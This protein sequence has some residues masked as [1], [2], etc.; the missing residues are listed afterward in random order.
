MRPRPLHLTAL[1]A[2]ALAA[3]TVANAQPAPVEADTAQARAHFDRGVL[4]FDRGDTEGALVEFQRAWELS[5]RPG[6]LFN[7]A[8]A[9]QAL[10]RYGEAAAALR[11]FLAEAPGD[12]PQ[13]PAA[14]RALRELE[15]LVAHV[16]VTVDPTDAVVTLDGRRQVDASDLV[17]GPGTHRIGAAREGFGAADEELTVASGE[18]RVVRLSLRPLAPVAP[19]LVVSPVAPA[20][21]PSDGGAAGGAMRT[22]AWVAGGSALALFGAGAAAFVLRESAVARFNDDARCLLD[23]GMT[24]AQN[25]AADE[26]TAHTAGAVGWAAVAVGGALAVTSAVLFLTAPRAP[27]ESARRLGCGVG[28]GTLGVSCGGTF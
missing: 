2:L 6:V 28:P 16:R 14:A 11:R 15:Q 1:V 18:E 24:R 20:P 12:H 9:A 21:T 27:R 26:S 5:R 17:V 19:A 10:R 8:A 7:V 4:L 13:R 25:C 3:P 22:L 23:N